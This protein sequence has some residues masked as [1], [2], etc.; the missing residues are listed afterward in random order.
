MSKFLNSVNSK[1]NQIESS[2]LKE[3]KKKKLELNWIDPGSCKSNQIW[4]LL[5]IPS[6]SP[7]HNLVFLV[8]PQLY[9][10]RHMPN[11]QHWRNK[12]NGWP[13]PR[14]VCL[15]SWLKNI[16]ILPFL[17]TWRFFILNLNVT[18]NELLL[19]MCHY[20]VK[21]LDI[22]MPVW[23]FCL[24]ILVFVWHNLKFTTAEHQ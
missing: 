12:V 1:F 24:E 21:T 11:S 16:Y 6:P 2:W 5:V 22:K 13:F 9:K 4:R 7:R 3:W 20:F 23:A 8:V 18:L 17:V 19:I 10:L 14:I 15:Y